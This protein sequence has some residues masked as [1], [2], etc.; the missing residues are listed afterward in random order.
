[1]RVTY[2]PPAD[3]RPPAHLT[4]QEYGAAHCRQTTPGTVVDLNIDELEAACRAAARV[5]RKGDAG[6]ITA[7][8]CTT[9]RKEG[10][11]AYVALIDQDEGALEPDWAAL[12]QYEGF[13]W[14]T[15]SHR[16]DKPS[17]RVVIPFVEP[18]AHGKIRCPFRGGFIRNRTQPAFLPT[19]LTDPERIEWRKL[20]GSKLLDAVE[21]GAVERA[22]EDRDSSLLAAA[23]QAAGMVERPQSGGVV[24]RCPWVHMHSDG[25]TGGT[26]VFHSDPDNRGFGKFHCARTECLKANRTS[27]DALNAIRNIPAV[28]EEL[29]HWPDPG[30]NGYQRSSTPVEPARAQALAGGAP[31]AP[32]AEAPLEIPEG[33]RATPET[34]GAMM[35][36]RHTVLTA[37]G[38][39]CRVL[40]WTTNELG[41][42]VAVL[43]SLADFKARYQAKRILI[44]GHK[45]PTPI[46]DWWLGWA[47]RDEAESLTFRPD[48]P[49]RRVDGKLNLWHGYGVAPKA[50]SWDRT[51]AFLREVVAG[52]NPA[53]WGYIIRWL[54]WVLQHPGDRAEVV[55]VLRGK[56]GT[57]KNTIL[58][59]LCKL[60]GQHAKTV[61]NSR[62]LVGHFNAHLADCALLFANEAIAASDKTA[63]AVLKTLVTDIT[64]PIERKGIDVEMWANRLS[65]C[66]A[67]NEDWCVPA[68][69][70]ERRFAVFDVSDAHIQDVAYFDAIHEEL[71]RK[72]CGPGH[73]AMLHDLLALDLK[74]W[75]PRQGVPKTEALVENQLD[76]LRGCDRVVYQMLATGIVA[77][78]S[79]V[80]PAPAP[81]GVFVPTSAVADDD[82]RR[83]VA[84]A[85]ALAKCITTE[86]GVRAIST[87]VAV[88]NGFG[89][90]RMSGFL[91]PSL[92]EARANWAKAMRLSPAWDDV[93][94]WVCE[95]LKD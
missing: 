82:Q 85:R 94:G 62:H 28:A 43:S 38:G 87:R 90:K 56:R 60:F 5:G 20:A 41:W 6:Y 32:T 74:G 86:S 57:G 54:A 19:H 8:E 16:P 53:H 33:L 49:D 26:A 39:K 24:V 58:D 92:S 67:S 11:P 31:V 13:A 15:A 73:A 66:M 76:G 59:A 78:Y 84:A 47:G 45:A 93:G 7:C 12:D 75:H 3:P 48:V 61:S 44:E 40:S 36:A 1:M 9:T 34:W 2:F 22:F 71:G 68:G 83:L 89:R 80:V 69:L 50:G 55:L 37:V 18:I 42:R 25:E 91:L 52:G 30:L 35:N 72:G 23:F 79:Q 14:T 10:G 65:L 70:D 77:G 29:R 64:I 81:G 27:W 95:D 51:Q 4:D 88:A 46:G 21:L 17:W 63:E